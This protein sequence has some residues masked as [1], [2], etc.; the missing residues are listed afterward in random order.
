MKPIHLKVS[1]FGAFA[2][3]Q[4]VPFSQLG[5]RSF[6]LIHGPTGAG[7]TSLLDAICFALYGDTS[8]GNRDAE[9]MRSDH[10]DPKRVTEVAFDFALGAEVYRVKRSP[11]QQRPKKKG[12]GFT[13]RDAEADV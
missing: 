5:G 8:G 3:E 7:K 12:A 10:A 11:R 2:G 6:F 13:T 9:G 4:E 1:A